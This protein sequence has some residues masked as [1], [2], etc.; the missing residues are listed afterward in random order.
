MSGAGRPPSI[1]VVVE[2][3]R[4]RY[5]DEER[6]RESVD[7]KITGLVALNAVILSVMAIGSEAAAIPVL[8]QLL[9]IAPVIGSVGVLL[10]QLGGTEYKRPVRHVSRF[11]AFAERPEDAVKEAFLNKYLGSIKKNRA[12][13]DRRFDLLQV[14]IAL[15]GLGLAVFLLASL[16]VLDAIAACLAPPGGAGG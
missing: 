7:T 3:V 10:H 5:D 6:R 1:D 8:W 4:R 2:E 15:T 13:N 9:S 12:T 16:G 11:S 14:G